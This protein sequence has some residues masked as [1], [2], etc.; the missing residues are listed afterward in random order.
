MHVLK[1]LAHSFVLMSQHLTMLVEAQWDILV[2]AD[3][4]MQKT[5]TWNGKDLINRNNAVL[6]GTS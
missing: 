3:M 6:E 2:Q 1:S 5:M 4:L